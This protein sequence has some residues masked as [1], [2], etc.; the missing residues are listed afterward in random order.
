MMVPLPLLVAMEVQIGVLRL[1]ERSMTYC[2]AARAGPAD[3]T[4][5]WLLGGTLIGADV[6]EARRGI[7]RVGAGQIFMEVV[8]AVAIGVGI[9]LRKPII[10]SEEV[11]QAP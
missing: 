4:I 3:D 10:Q 9:C 7:R 8:H 5:L 2:F 1:G 11:A 6:L